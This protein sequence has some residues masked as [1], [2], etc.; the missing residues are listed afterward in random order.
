[1]ASQGSFHVISSHRICM[2]KHAA[3]QAVRIAGQRTCMPIFPSCNNMMAIQ[4][5][6]P[7]KHMTKVWQQVRTTPKEKTSLFVE[8]CCSRMTCTRAGNA[9]LRLC[10]TPAV[11][12]WGK[13]HAE[14]TASNCPASA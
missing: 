13:A 9:L 12:T 4:S 6:E 8:K 7:A 14:A 5:S 3:E 10:A 1:M 11:R 2:H